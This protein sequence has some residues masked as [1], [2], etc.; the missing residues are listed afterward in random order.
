MATPNPGAPAMKHALSQQGKTPSQSQQ[1]AAA[2]PPVS[3]PFSVAHA[4]FSPQGPRSSPQQVKKSPAVASSATLGNHPSNTHINFD[5]PAAAAAFNALLIPGDIASMDLG[6]RG[7][8]GLGALGGSSEDER[9]KRLDE[10]IAILGESKGLVSE[11]GIVRLA[12]SLGFETLW[13][14]GKGVDAAKK[15]LIIGGR[16]LELIIVF[17]SPDVVES[18]SVS[19]EATSDTV[20]KHNEDAGRILTENLRLASGQLPL[21]KKMDKFAKNLERIAILD[22]LSIYPVLNLHEAVAGIY[23]SLKKL[24]AWE[25]E[26]T[27]KEASFA[28]KSDQ[29]IENT[30]LCTG[31]GSPAMNRRDKLGITLDYW[32]EKRL[33]EGSDG[34]MAEYI[35][36]NES[37]WT[38]LI[39]CAPLRDLG[40]HQIHPVRISNDWISDNIV[41]SPSP[42]PGEPNTP[43]TIDWLEP[44][45]TYITPDASKEAGGVDGLG[46]DAP[47]LGPRLPEVVFHA[48]FEPPVIIPLG[49]WQNIQQSGTAIPIFDTPNFDALLFPIAPGASSYDPSE[50]RTIT[51][52]APVPGRP[53]S[54]EA[55]YKQDYRRT[56]LV[57]KPIYGREL[58]E[59]TFSH[60]RQLV[61][62]LPSLRQYAFLTTV[63]EKTFKPKCVKHREE[64]VSSPE[65]QRRQQQT[66]E[67]AGSMSPYSE[68]IGGLVD[69]SEESIK[70]DVTL[71]LHPVPRLQVI[72]PFRDGMANVVLEIRLNGAVTVI[73]QDVLDERNA[74]APDGRPRREEDLAEFLMWIE[75]LSAWC[76]FIRTRWA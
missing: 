33:Q 30:V 45:E 3:T 46:A 15:T 73:Y 16:A 7:P 1:G 37:V 31:S 24:H 62:M 74:V 12:K 38:I 54:D 5:S 71:T 69:Q 60:P 58:S 51:C 18:V 56:L 21:T 11:A 66:Q 25:V 64:S 67:E 50:P 52:I 40:V 14:N 28:L 63:L 34:R 44:E 55:F 68:L 35:A 36:Q 4:A 29:F 41:N 42:L 9:T 47:L 49:L 19:F 22:N 17:S 23:E 8:D 2:T 26:K 76:E 53:K 20:N 27:K 59:L 61:E 6:L 43:P 57:Y 65:K 13:E 72:F 75:D 32:M 39:R 48:T 10:V 70:M